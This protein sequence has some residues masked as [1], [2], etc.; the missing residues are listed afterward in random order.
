MG[1]TASA[2]LWKRR[3]VEMYSEQAANQITKEI[4]TLAHCPK[5]SRKNN[6]AGHIH[7]IATS[8]AAR[9]RRFVIIFIGFVIS[10]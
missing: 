6:D 1:S 10:S 9:H 8:P 3:F 2:N 5:H 7:K 4:S